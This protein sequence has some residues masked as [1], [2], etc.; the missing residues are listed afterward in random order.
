M[1]KRRSTTQETLVLALELL[2]RIPRNHKISAPELHRQLREAG[3]ERGLRT[4]QRQLEVLCEHFDIERDERSK[5][6]GYHWKL[7]ARGMSVPMLSAQESLLLTLAEAQLHH[8]LPAPLLQS[9][10]GFFAQARYN[11]HHNDH[12]RKEEAWLKKVRVVSE[13]QPLLPPRIYPGVFD[14][15]S[16]ALYTDRWLQVD[17]VNGAGKENVAEVMPLGLAQQGVRLYLVCRYRG[18]DDERSLALHRMRKAKALTMTFDRP[19]NFDLARYEAE[20]R[21]SFGE[22]KP[23]KLQFCVVKGPADHL[24]ETP[25]SSNQVM[26]DQGDHYHVTTTVIDSEQLDWWLRGFGEQLWAV[27]KRG[28]QDNI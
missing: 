20:G 27:E 6:Y 22:G 13:T 16:E 8:L 10:A 15:V 4:I 3:I 9:M 18:Y 19:K 2:R 28:E 17:Y 21:F 25:L 12:R 14:A 7:Q 23:I 5:P 11:L 1:N 24:L 26:V